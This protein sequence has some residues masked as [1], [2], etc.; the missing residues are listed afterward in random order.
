MRQPHLGDSV[1]NNNTNNYNNNNNIMNNKINNSNNNNN[2]RDTK[3]YKTKLF[4]DLQLN[5]FVLVNVLKAY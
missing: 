3:N 2:N 5:F 1:N 4:I